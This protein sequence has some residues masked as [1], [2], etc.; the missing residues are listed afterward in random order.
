MAIKLGRML[1][2]AEE[3]GGPAPGASRRLPPGFSRLYGSTQKGRLLESVPLGVTTWTVPVVAPAGMVVEMAVPV[4][5]TVKTAIPVGPV[6]GK[7]HALTNGLYR[8][9]ER[10]GKASRL[11]DFVP[12][13]HVPTGATRPCQSQGPRFM[14]IFRVFLA[15]VNRLTAF[16]SPYLGPQELR[17]LGNSL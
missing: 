17:P 13:G 15:P 16:R 12:R 14:G 1:I 8:R 9:D 4:E 7:N 10:R 6:L 2:L 11:A 3:D 5:L